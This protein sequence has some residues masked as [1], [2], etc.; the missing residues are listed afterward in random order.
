MTVAFSTSGEETS[1]VK[2][3]LMTLSR[4]PTMH[5]AP[6]HRGKSVSNIGRL[7]APCKHRWRL[8]MLVKEIV[9]VSLTLSDLIVSETLRST[10]EL[11]DSMLVIHIL[12]VFKSL[13]ACGKVVP[14]GT[15]PSPLVFL[16]E[17]LG[18]N[19]AIIQV[20]PLPLLVLTGYMVTGEHF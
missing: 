18:L 2:V 3:E 15:I 10:L 11:W 1:S 5:A 8:S 17:G 12:R 20:L 13:Y 9:N 6:A 14:N 7:V 16:T 19:D 4:C